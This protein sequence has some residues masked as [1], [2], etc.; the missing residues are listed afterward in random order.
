MI[1]ITENSLRDGHQS[2]L[3]TRMR[4]E[5]MIEAAQAFEQ[6]GFYSVEVWGGATYDACL[7]YLKED[8]F[9]RLAIFKEIFKKT[10]IQMLLRGQ[11]LIVDR[12]FWDTTIMQTM[13][14]VSLCDFPLKMGWIFLE[15][16]MR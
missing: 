7:R 16:L 10:P 8:P 6:V 15:S 2:L 5:D 3:A 12:T 13:W 14:C 11:N 1:K 4:T 9:E